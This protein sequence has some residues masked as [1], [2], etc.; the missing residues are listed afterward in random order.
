MKELKRMN[1]NEWIAMNE[2]KWK[3]WKEGIQV[4]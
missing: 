3:N 4:S 2:L 1:P